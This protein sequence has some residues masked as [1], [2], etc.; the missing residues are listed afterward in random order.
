MAKF[1]TT[2]K[3]DLLHKFISKKHRPFSA[4]LAFKDGKTQFEFAPRPAKGAKPKAGAKKKEPETE[5]PTASSE[6]KA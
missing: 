3:T 5:A 1:L 6:P 4:Y 2:G